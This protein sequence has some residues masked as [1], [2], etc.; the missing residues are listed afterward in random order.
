MRCRQ[1]LAK[2]FINNGDRNKICGENRR[3]GDEMTEKDAILMRWAIFQMMARSK[4]F[5]RWF[6]A[7]VMRYRRP[8]RYA[9][10]R[11]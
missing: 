11:L 7:L 4:L 9:Y 10:P 2:P 6:E 5:Q 8:P 1:Q 3:D